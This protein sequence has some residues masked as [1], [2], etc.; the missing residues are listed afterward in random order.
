MKI[1][2]AMA[3]YNGQDYI[4]Q[5]LKSILSQSVKPDEV[6]ISDDNSTDETLDV[7]RSVIRTSNI[8]IKLISN[9]KNMGYTQN[10]NNALLH[11]SGDVVFLCDQDDY[12]Y[13]NKIS[14]MMKT[15][16]NNDKFLV[17]MNDALLTDEN[18]NPSKLTKIG[19]IRSASLDDS[20]FVMGCCCA[21]KRELLDFA[22][23]IPSQFKG[24][25]D[26]LV[27]IAD[28]LNKKYIDSAIL[29]LYRR[30]GANESSFLPNSLKRVT[31]VDIWKDSAARI[32][33]DRQKNE[34][35]AVKHLEQLRIFLSEIQAIRKRVPNNYQEFYEEFILSSNKKLDVMEKRHA[36]RRRA[37]VYRFIASIGF[38]FTLYPKRTRLQNMIRDI[39]G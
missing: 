37:I 11:T 23:P 34:I 15:I 6:I 1:S 20:F 29:Q 32:F 39:I 35:D 31:L 33:S 9:S 21:I 25:D 7:I 16:E 38:F 19:Q 26:W 10:F 14:H 12:W 8:K 4:E 27:R 3:T 5:Q 17:Y 30:H 24:H 22:L 13:E 2:V 28:G 36:L 18:L